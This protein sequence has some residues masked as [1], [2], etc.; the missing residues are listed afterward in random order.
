[1]AVHSGEINVNA[2]DGVLDGGGEP[3]Q[4]GQAREDLV[5][6]LLQAREILA[7]GLQEGRPYQLIRS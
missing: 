6:S 7:N 1:V 3:F 2:D 4:R 5:L